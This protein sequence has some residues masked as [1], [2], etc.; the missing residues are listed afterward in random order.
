MTITKR[1]NNNN[2]CFIAIANQK[3]TI[4]QLLGKGHV[5]EESTALSKKV[6]VVNDILLEGFLMHLEGVLERY[7]AAYMLS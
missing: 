6:Q 4:R 2:S 7:V 5:K 1:K 3:A